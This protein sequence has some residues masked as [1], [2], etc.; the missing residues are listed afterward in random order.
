M[1][2]FNSALLT[3]LSAR[4]FIKDCSSAAGLDCLLAS[5][6][7]VAVYCGFDP[8]AASLH[9]G[10]LVSLTLLRRFAAAGHRVIP[11]LGTATALVGDP[12][13]RSSVRPMLD[14]STLEAN[15]RGIETSIRLGLGP[16]VEAEILSSTLR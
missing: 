5:G 9:V 13:G 8:T 6:E 2:V 3:E 10:H 16:E 7:K 11:V 12:S 4:G 15:S 1:T 14:Q